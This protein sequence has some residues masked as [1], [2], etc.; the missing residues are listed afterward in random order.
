ME[1]PQSFRKL[2]GRRRAQVCSLLALP[3]AVLAV[4]LS[5]FSFTPVAAR[6]GMVA[7][8]EPLATDAGVQIL[9]QGGNA[10]DAA[11][12]VGFALAVT[13][14]VAGNL[15]GGGFMLIRLA[16]GEAVVVDYREAAPAA[17]SRNMYIGPDGQVS[18][19][20][21]TVGALAAGIPGTVAGLVLAEQKYGR[22]KLPSVLGPPSNWPNRA[23]WSATPS[24]SRSARI[25]ISSPSS[26][27]PA[28]SSCATAASTSRAIFSSSRSWRPRRGRGQRGG[29]GFLYRQ[30]GA[31]GGR[32][33]AEVPW[34]YH[35]AGSRQL[36][37]RPAPAALRPFSRLRLALGP[38]AQ[39]GWRGSDRDA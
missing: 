22:L 26:T 19:P 17:A 32:H 12:A 7:S 34:P 33:H 37:A 23:S 35:R 9:L 11:V 6:H 27:L 4:S 3:L 13:H 18:A 28:A 21:S 8:S 29:K 16:N 30:G 14:P 10:V 1:Y 24:A 36:P 25:R 31:G 39:R 38:A 2:P 20:A 5:A 15:G